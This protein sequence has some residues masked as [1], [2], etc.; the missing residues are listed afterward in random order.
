[1]ESTG[2]HQEHVGIERAR[3]LPYAQS[4]W[5]K[6]LPAV[7]II[8]GFVIGVALP[9]VV[10]PFPLLAAAP[11]AAAPL[12]SLSGTVVTGV[13]AL[14]I[15]TFHV[16]L[17]GGPFDINDVAFVSISILTVV[18]VGIN[19]LMARDRRL[20]KTA[21]DVAE[22]VQRAVLPS[23]PHRIG[24]LIIAA[25]Y[26]AAQEEAAIGGDLYAV[27]ET[28][29]GTRLLIADVRG[30]GLEAVE[31]VT[32]VLG[33]FYEAAVQ[34]PNLPDVVHSLEGAVRRLN[35]LRS[36]PEMA[37]GTPE[38]F[39]TAAVV[40]VSTDFRTLR[41][42][43]RGHPPPLLLLSEGQIRELEPCT[44]SL[45][46]GLADLGGSDVP[47]DEFELS[48]GATLVL[49]TDGVTEAR[50]RRGAFY[51]PVH[52]LSQFIPPGPE[53]VLDALIA[54]LSRHAGPRLGDDAALLAVTRKADTETAPDP[55]RR[56]L[57]HPHGMTW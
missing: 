17:R 28:P 51:D 54:D 45:P 7:L 21:R 19:R 6:L 11:V 22:A 26:A 12:L 33:S 2:N 41:V 52:G 31:A 18:A 3:E 1:M 40:E 10:S 32:R 25:R 8:G 50:N 57:N 27:Q 37:E 55:R 43:N 15:G 36:E 46:L 56:S 16:F 49:F 42:A 9:G 38:T 53:E 14:L 13:V 48:Q 44:P 47:V 30:K 34:T 20:L 29:Y 4:R 23:P 24:P 35:A 5:Y 39:A